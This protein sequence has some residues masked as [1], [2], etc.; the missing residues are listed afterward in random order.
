MKPHL[1][2]TLNE[3]LLAVHIQLWH[4]EHSMK[5]INISTVAFQT[6]QILR[7]KTN[8]NSAL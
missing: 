6:K 5:T 8:T 3:Y 4:M 7:T 2:Q 1:L